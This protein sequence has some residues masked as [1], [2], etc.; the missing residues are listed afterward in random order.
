ML[1]FQLSIGTLCDFHHGIHIPFDTVYI[2]DEL[3]GVHHLVERII[4]SLGRVVLHGVHEGM[5]GQT[6]VLETASLEHGGGLGCVTRGVGGDGCLADDG[7]GVIQSN[8]GLCRAAGAY[9]SGKTKGLGYVNV[10]RLHV[11]VDIADNELRQSLQGDGFQSGEATDEQMRQS[12][13]DTDDVVG[14]LAAADTTV[15][16][17]DIG[18]HIGDAVYDGVGVHAGDFQL[19]SAIAFKQTIQEC[20]GC[21]VGTHPAVLPECFEE[22]GGGF[23]H[24]QTH[25]AQVLQPAYICLHGVFD[26]APLTILCD[27]GL[28]VVTGT[29]TADTVFSHPDRIELLQFV[30]NKIDDGIQRILNL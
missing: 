18:H 4:V 12:F 27:T 28:V 5:I 10:E 1:V 26:T 19:I 9:V 13:I 3:D 17:D 2:L 14:V 11:L 6:H 7:E 22:V 25:H 21:Q 16:A 23:G 15:I 24:H 8:T 30:I 29:L 20:E